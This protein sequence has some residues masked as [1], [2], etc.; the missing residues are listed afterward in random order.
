MS[1]STL[2]S[3]SWGR[4]ATGLNHNLVAEHNRCRRMTDFGREVCGNLDVSATRQWLVTNGMGGYA[5]GTMA[6]LLI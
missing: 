3:P 4:P 5:S 1:S 6:G 2:R